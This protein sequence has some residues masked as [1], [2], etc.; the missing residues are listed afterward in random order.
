[1]SEWE[2]RHLV[3]AGFCVILL[4]IL[5]IITIDLIPIL[6]WIPMMAF[7]LKASLIGAGIGSLFGHE[8][9]DAEKGFFV[10]FIVVIGSIS[11]LLVVDDIF[12][13]FLLDL[14]LLFL[15]FLLLAASGITEEMTGSNRT[16]LEAF[17]IGS[18]LVFAGV[19]LANQIGLLDSITP[20]LPHVSVILVISAVVIC[21]FIIESR[22]SDSS[23]PLPLPI[24]K[25]VSTTDKIAEEMP[26]IS[27]P[28]PDET[29]VDELKRLLYEL[30]VPESIV[31]RILSAGFAT[32]TDLIAAK[33]DHLAA[34]AGVDVKGAEDLLMDIQ[35]KVWFGGI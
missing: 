32:V 16:F 28:V 18:I 26:E 11:T 25:G 9:E 1:M 22:N 8:S 35:K 34:V 24:P 4:F 33:P 17:S 30:E 5:G 13:P 19:M 29:S 23:D 2:T 3:A 10:G 31:N 20:I 12:N 7:G 27:R 15:F 14:I 6:G 21:A